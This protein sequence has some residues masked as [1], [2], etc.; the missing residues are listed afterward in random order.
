MLLVRDPAGKTI[1]IAFYD[2]TRGRDIISK[3]CKIGD[4]V[5][6]LYPQR[7]QFLDGQIGFR[8]EDEQ[9]KNIKV[10]CG[11]DCLFEY[12]VCCLLLVVCLLPFGFS[13]V[14]FVLFGICRWWDAGVTLT[15]EI[16]EFKDA[17]ANG[18][19]ENVLTRRNTPGV[20]I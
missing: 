17:N 8:I 13:R 7:Y 9:V 18:G 11:S 10:C 2:S 3:G 16:E 5:L 6:L 1:T 15:R 20:V 19:D 14:F 4:T 12:V